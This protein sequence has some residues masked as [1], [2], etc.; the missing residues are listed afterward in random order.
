MFSLHKE[1]PL[2]GAIYATQD[3]KIL[4]IE[5]IPDE[6]FASK[7]LGD[8][9]CIVPSDG[10]V[11]APVEGVIESIADANHAFGIAASDGADIMIHIGVDTVELSG[12]GFEPK[13]RL[14]QRVKAGDLLCQVDLS[15]I[16]KAG[17]A[18]HTAVLLT[19]PDTFKIV[20]FCYGDAAGG[21]TVAFRY[22]KTTAAESSG[23]RG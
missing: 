13:V 22:Q 11:Y 7:V 23:E 16:R 21:K 19:N 8:G 12:S 6:V 18:I 3:G 17:Y 10:R 20:E 14:E 1:E 4:P 2:T 15:L 9:I 5:E